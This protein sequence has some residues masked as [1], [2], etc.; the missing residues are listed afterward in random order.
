[1][2]FVGEIAALTAAFFW[3][4][5]TL[6]FESAGKKIGAFPTNLLRI[7]MACFLLCFS[8][9]VQTGLFFPIK[10]THHHY[11]W[12]GTSGII[13]LAIG[14]GALFFSIV[15]IGPRLATLLLS[16]APPLTT[17]IAWIFLGEVLQPLAV[18]G[19]VITVG[20]IIWVV[21][22]KQNRDHDNKRLI[23]GVILG[24]IA[25][26]GQAVGV[27]FAKIGLDIAIDSLS[28][29]I[30]RMVPSAFFLWIVAFLT[31]QAKPT[32]VAFKNKSALLA[33]IGGSIFGPFIGVW[34]SIVAVKY[35]QAG[36]AATLLATVPILVIPLEIIVHK[37]KP[38]LRAVTGTICAIFGI[39]LIFLR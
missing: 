12:L 39:T 26:L 32:L 28:A 3:G 23:K 4:F 16:F 5:C 2:P 35:T 9:F 38:S 19:I 22:E 13:G 8:L 7:V 33:T 1:M 30:L 10:A 11:L 6:L 20:S 34:L 15:I 37:R 31:R 29:T 21:S 17:L 18:L 24:L 36:I 27:I 14:D 25:A